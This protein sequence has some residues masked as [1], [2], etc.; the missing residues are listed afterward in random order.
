MNGDYEPR[1]ATYS[2]EDFG[3]ETRADFHRDRCP[4]CGATKS[5]AGELCCGT[6]SSYRA[7]SRASDICANCNGAGR[8]PDGVECDTCAGTGTLV[9]QLTGEN[10]RSGVD[11]YASVMARKYDPYSASMDPDFPME[12]MERVAGVELRH[13]AVAELRS[14]GTISPRTARQVGQALNYRWYGG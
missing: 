10:Q 6:T 12:Q 2:R 3:L 5:W 14:L 4:R 1:W 8:F 11:L 13:Q 7:S 9:G